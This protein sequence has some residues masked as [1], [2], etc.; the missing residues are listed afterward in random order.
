MD[1]TATVEGTVSRTVVSGTVETG[2]PAMTA[3]A[4]RPRAQSVERALRVLRCFE[5][6]DGELGVSEVGKRTGLTVST[7][8][9]LT[10]AL[11]DAGL[12]TQDPLTDRYRLGPALVVLGSRA[13]H[14]LGYPRA[15]PALQRL[16]DGT[17]EAAVLGIA[18]GGEVLVVLDTA[19]TGEPRLARTPALD[20]C[21]RAFQPR[22]ATGDLAAVHEHGWT[23]DDGEGNPGVRAVAA[24]VLDQAGYAVAAIAV[25]GPRIHLTDDRLPSVVDAVCA[26]AGEIAGVLAGAPTAH[27]AVTPAR[28]AQPR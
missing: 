6:A 7:A 19:A 2:T 23:L 27:Q 11:R 4:G 20:R 8:H 13:A 21:L 17:G 22:G 10:Q 1:G 24:P 9:R 18:S 14:L 16:A 3:G 5:D 26:T 25:H 28:R 15:L 12:L